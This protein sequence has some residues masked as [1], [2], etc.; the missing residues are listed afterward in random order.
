MLLPAI[1][2]ASSERWSSEEARLIPSLE[3]ADMP[4]VSILTISESFPLT[5]SSGML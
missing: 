4:N 1:G 2:I 3:E 5:F